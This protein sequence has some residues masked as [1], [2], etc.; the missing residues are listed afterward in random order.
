MLI[1]WA[2]QQ[3]GF[4]TPPST[5]KPSDLGADLL[6][7]WDAEVFASLTLAGSLVNAWADQVGGYSLAQTIG[8]LKPIY[9]ATSLNGRPGVT[10]DGTDDYL[11]SALLPA[12]FPVGAGACEMWGLTSQDFA[13]A[14][15]GNQT[16]ITYG[17]LGNLNTRTLRR[18]PSGGVNRAI[19]F[20]TNQALDTVVDFSGIH[21]ARGIVGATTVGISVDGNTTTSVAAVPATGSPGAVALGAIVTGTNRFWKGPMNA[22]LVTNPLSAPNAALLLQFLKTRGGLP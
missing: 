3:A 7:Y 1:S 17:D 11:L 13:A 21:V 10:F 18:G 12:S 8:S 19:T 14:Q 5:W 22:V 2:S 9:S 6:G 16:I 15:T 4:R 20:A